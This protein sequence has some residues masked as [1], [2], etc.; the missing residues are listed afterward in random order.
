M[1]EL[2]E[3]EFG[4]WRLK[5]LVTDCKSLNPDVWPLVATFPLPYFQTK[6]INS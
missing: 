6:A 3:Q 4:G 1:V 2:V 5:V